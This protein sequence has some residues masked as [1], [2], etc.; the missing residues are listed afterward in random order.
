MGVQYFGTANCMMNVKSSSKDISASNSDQFVMVV[1]M[2]AVRSV[3]S[4][5]LVGNIHVLYNPNR[6]DIK[7]GQVR[8]FLESAQRLSQ[9][10]GDIPVVLAGDLNSMPQVI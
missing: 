7:L 4:R 2:F 10:W 5:F 8:L 1:Q 6:G 9:E 3:S